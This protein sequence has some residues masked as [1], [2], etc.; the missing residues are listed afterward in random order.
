MARLLRMKKFYENESNET[1]A[2]NKVVKISSLNGAEIE[3][4]EK[5]I[6]FGHENEP[7]MQH[8]QNIKCKL[9]NKHEDDE[10]NKSQ[11]IQEA[12]ELKFKF[13]ALVLD[14]LFF[15]IA[16]FYSILTFIGLVLSI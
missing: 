5:Y 1:S 10:N 13:A 2:E 3:I 12:K 14:R 6:S 11:Q 9:N 8:A 4:S 16:L 7:L 15:Y